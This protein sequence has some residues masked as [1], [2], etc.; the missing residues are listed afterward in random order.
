MKIEI[1]TW[2]L[3]TIILPFRIKLMN[4]DYREIEKSE[5]LDN[6]STCIKN[7]SEADTAT[8]ILEWQER[9]MDYW[10]ERAEAWIVIVS[11]LLLALFFIV[12]KCSSGSAIFLLVFIFLVGCFLGN[13]FVVIMK[14][15]HYIKKKYDSSNIND[16]V[17]LSKLTFIKLNIPIEQI[18][19][20]R[21][22]HCREYARLSAAILLKLG[23]DPFFVLISGHVAT[24]V[25]INKIFYV[26]D[27]S[28][29]IKQL[30]KWL[31]CNNAKDCWLLKVTRDDI[32]K[33]VNIE[34][35]YKHTASVT[36]TINV[37]SIQ[38]RNIERLQNDITDYF[39][40]IKSSDGN[41]CGIPCKV[42][43]GNKTAFFYDEIAHL[44]IV[45]LSVMEI[46]QK[47]CNNISK[48]SGIKVEQ[49]NEKLVAF[50]YY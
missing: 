50:V 25:K 5:L 23:I 49:M 10:Y 35:M 2:I 42:P 19:K 7:G 27:Q 3:K 20:C 43:I 31:N 36:K 18:I 38:Q 21:Q 14:Y 45:R 40:L 28:L 32:C 29:P 30:D 41:I 22:G 33:E 4:I 12:C 24:A 17:N 16:L 39:K 37:P 26:I 48:I 8:N 34:L 47:F 15:W 1:H 6:L 46:E 9:N 11:S 44:S 13:L